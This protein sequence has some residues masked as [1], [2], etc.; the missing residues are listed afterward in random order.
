M[1]RVF[2]WMVF[3]LVLTSAPVTWAQSPPVLIR[4][5]SAGTIVTV[6]VNSDGELTINCDSGCGGSTVEDAAHGS[7]DLGAFILGVRRDTTPSSSA[8][9][10]GDYAAIN[11]DENGRMYVQAL[12]TD[13]GG[14]EVS[15]DEDA[16]HTSADP[17]YPI[18]AIRRDTTPSS[19]SGTAGDYSALNADAN[20]RLYTQAV[21][22]NS[23]G[24]EL[25]VATDV[26]EDAAETAGGTGPMVLNVRRNVAA[27]SAGTTGDNATFNSDALG[28]LWTRKLD[29]CSGVAK[30]YYVVNIATAQGSTVGTEIANAVASEYWHICSVNLVTNAAN[31]INI[32]TDDTDGCGSLTAG[33]NGGNSA[34]TGWYLAANG[35]IAL[36]NG[37]STVMKSA[38]ANHYLC[39]SQSA[40]TQLSGTIVYVSAP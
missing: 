18:W 34:T 33:L 23:S 25:T 28:L 35:G 27:S 14:A 8:G 15:K 9:T 37:D 12:L 20:G 29:P 6:K 5:V 19:S 38:T 26:T 21:I 3:G 22:Y 16:A 4:G 24:T 30:N 36:G 31:V 39:I 40:S 13:A 32:A 11:V 10:A 7:G 17:G 1:R 2:W